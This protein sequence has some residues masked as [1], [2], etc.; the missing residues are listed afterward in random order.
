MDK[1]IDLY[2]FPTTEAL[3]C[4][5]GCVTVVACVRHILPIL[6]L[7]LAVEWGHNL[8]ITWVCKAMGNMGLNLAEPHQQQWEISDK[9]T[10]ISILS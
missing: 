5:K 8:T 9:D 7:R 4:A 1:I 10:A 3:A 6:G 2:E